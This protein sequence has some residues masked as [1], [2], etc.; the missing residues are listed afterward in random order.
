[1]KKNYSNED[2]EMIKKMFMENPDKHFSGDKIKLMFNINTIKLQSIIHDLRLENE[3]VVSC[4]N[5]G[6][7]YTTNVEEIMATY[8]SLIGRANS[9]LQAANG[10]L[11]CIE[12][13]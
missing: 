6:Y 11:F 7:K 8:Q 5:L 2:Y 9:I 13:K 4:G 3:P 1:M 10:L 12:S